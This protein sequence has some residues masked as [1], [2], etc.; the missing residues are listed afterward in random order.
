MLKR[1]TK[2]EFVERAEKVHGNKYDYSKTEYVNA[3]TKVCIIC[4]EHGEFEQKPDHHLAGRGC[5][6]CARGKIG[7]A[8][9]RT[10]EEFVRIANLVHNGKYDYSKTEYIN[11]CVKICV[12]CPIH[13]EFWQE[14]HSHLNGC[15]CPQCYTESHTKKQEEFVQQ[16]KD[17]HGGKYDYSQSKYVRKD[18]KIKIICPEHG[19]FWQT[20]NCHLGGQGCPKCANERR[21]IGVLGV[22]TLDKPIGEKIE[23]SELIWRGILTR[24]YDDGFKKTR[25]TYSDCSV[26]V[27]W[28]EYENFKAWY[29]E[30]YVEG[31]ELDK[32]ILVKGNKEYAP[33]KCCFVPPQ[34][35]KLFMSSKSRR[36]KYPIGVYVSNSGR[37]ASRVVMGDM[38]KYLGSFDTPEEA[39]E[40]YK[41]AKEAWIKEVADKY[42]DQLDPKAY[43]AMYEYQ[44]EI[45]D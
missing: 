9:R 26:C 11:K 14:A 1:L 38:E 7:M 32:D 19:E 39:F 21:R 15:G 45:T 23:R 8:N 10:C 27:E 28:R 4:P 22:G 30:H 5:P 35:N 44:V 6:V 16:A 37:Y 25:P 2:E 41:I 29:N 33:D 31:W 40:A 42:K 43:K 17:I 12:I 36:G 18:I 24:G 13:G 20:P 34:I 3:R